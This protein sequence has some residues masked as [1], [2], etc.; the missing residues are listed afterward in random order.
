MSIQE[1]QLALRVGP[2]L[3]PLA[4]RDLMAALR[5]VEV[6]QTDSAPSG[7][8]LTF[9]AEA[10]ASAGESFDIVANW[11]L[12]PFN[13]VLVRVAVDGDAQTL[14]DGFITHH[15]FVPSNGPEESQFVVTGEDVSVRLDLDEVSAEFPAAPDVALVEAILDP[16]LLELGLV[17]VVIP[18][19]TED[20]PW[21]TVPQQ[22]ESD[23]AMLQRLAQR[24]GNVFFVE[25]TGV[26]YVNAAYWGPPPRFRPL[27]GVLDL[28]GFS[29]VL[30]SF[31]GEYQA[32]APETYYG[33]V[34]ETEVDPYEPVPILTLLSERLPPFVWDPALNP[35]SVELGNVR[36]LLWREEQMDPLRAESEAQ[37][38]TD[39][40]T[41]NVVTVNCEA[42]TVAIGKV[43]RAPGT[44]GVRGAGSQ[45]D[46]IYY[47]KQATHRIQ[48]LA[49]ERWDY[50][51]ALVLT[52]EG[53][54][55]LFPRL[56][57]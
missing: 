20:V 28:L 34:L 14:I 38:R 24:N 56:A 10:L 7:F 11:L 43:L 19:L 23:R 4:S 41:D 42:P 30:T 25:P 44:V 45:Y 52:R 9:H 46:G 32:L 16:W 13:R 54:G 48:L 40:S 1:I 2:V 29:S 36:R 8:Q 22:E 50:T 6:T 33:F 12:Q 55:N 53:V 35:L 57:A 31:T 15:Q 49:D 37:G 51:Q 39:Q 21:E 18:P 5:G 3:P 17:S 26:L 47:L 27:G